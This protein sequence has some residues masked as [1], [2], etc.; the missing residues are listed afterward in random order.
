M[1][2]S[3][4]QLNCWKSIKMHVAKPSELLEEVY[5]LTVTVLS[6]NTLIL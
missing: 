1:D 2:G 5:L 3:Q 4:K 6:V